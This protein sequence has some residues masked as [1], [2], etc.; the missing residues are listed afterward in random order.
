MILINNTAVLYKKNNKRPT[1]RK[2]SKPLI[3]KK[4]VLYAYNAL[5]YSLAIISDVN[6]AG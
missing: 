5:S 4:E 6:A 3:F 2:E 1:F